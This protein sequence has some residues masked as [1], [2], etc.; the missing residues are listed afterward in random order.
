MGHHSNLLLHLFGLVFVLQT[1]RLVLHDLLLLLIESLVR[2]SLLSILL[3]WHI[4]QLLTSKFK[5]I[6]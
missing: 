6:I 3:G 5:F 1:E 2:G 4:F